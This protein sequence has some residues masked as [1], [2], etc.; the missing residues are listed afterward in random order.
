MPG[1][2]TSP[3]LGP[4]VPLGQGQSLGAGPLGRAYGP[5]KGML[6]PATHDFDQPTKRRACR[7]ALA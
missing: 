6:V 5:P 4:A 3:N 7:T 1:G 2:T